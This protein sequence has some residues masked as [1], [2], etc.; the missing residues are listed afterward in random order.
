MATQPDVAVLALARSAFYGTDVLR[1]VST[2]SLALNST[3][4]LIVQPG[5]VSLSV[6][7]ARLV[8][9]PDRRRLPSSAVRPRIRRLCL[10]EADVYQ[11]DEASDDDDMSRSSDGD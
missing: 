9:S 8:R 3:A 5:V 11:A 1:S 4:P 6:R 7:P 10:R 2:A